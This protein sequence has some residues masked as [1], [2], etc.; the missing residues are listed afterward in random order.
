VW[1]DTGVGAEDMKITGD[2]RPDFFKGI[3]SL[4]MPSA[5]RILFQSRAN[6]TN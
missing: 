6:M 4:H 2:A 5:V 3:V 1:F